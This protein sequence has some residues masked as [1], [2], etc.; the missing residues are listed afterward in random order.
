MEG[1][2]VA[3]YEHGTS[4]EDLRLY[5]KLTR[6]QFALKD[7]DVKYQYVVYW[8]NEDLLFT[9]MS[10][11]GSKPYSYVDYVWIKMI[12]KLKELG[13]HFKII[14]KAKEHMLGPPVWS[15][16]IDKTIDRQISEDPD[17][18]D[19]LEKKRSEL[20]EHA[21]KM[22]FFS[23]LVTEHILQKKHLSFWINTEGEVNYFTDKRMPRL[24]KGGKLTNFY[25]HTFVSVSLTEVIQETINRKDLSLVQGDLEVINIEEKRVLDLIA[26][27]RLV[28]L[29]VHTDEGDTVD[30]VA[31]TKDQPTELKSRFI[32][33]IT[34]GAYEKISYTTSSGTEVKF[35]KLR[36]KTSSN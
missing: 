14:R 33:I 25:R 26:S 15:Y 3:F 19:L 34:N 30:L 2:L 29:N 1:F 9:N 23:H 31:E 5:E 36:P 4:A 17:K 21:A 11:K 22:T 20:H 27:K 7:M 18:R 35:S 32:N 28:E 8:R 6:P 16:G 12:E 13:I 10:G 24:R